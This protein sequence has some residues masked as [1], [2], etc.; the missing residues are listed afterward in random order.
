MSSCLL[1]WL[2]GGALGPDFAPVGGVLASNAP[3]APHSMYTCHV[4]GYCACHK[5]GC[6]C[7]VISITCVML[8]SV[9]VCDCEHCY[10]ACASAY[11]ALFV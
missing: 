1:V 5:Y 10:H 11:H 7:H 4:Y 3:P 6:K 8:E 2:L 9:M